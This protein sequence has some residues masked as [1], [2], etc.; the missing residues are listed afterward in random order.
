M[1]LRNACGRS[2]QQA[3]LTSTIA[4][5]GLTEQRLRD[6]GIDGYAAGEPGRVRCKAHPTSRATRS[7]A[8]TWGFHASHQSPRPQARVGMSPTLTGL[9]AD[10]HH[11][12]SRPQS[13]ISIGCRACC[14]DRM[15]RLQ[16]GEPDAHRC[17][18]ASSFSCWAQAWAGLQRIV[19]RRPPRCV[20]VGPS[21]VSS[22]PPDQKSARD[23]HQ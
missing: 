5:T 20:R 22:P 21:P 14:N 16:V 23:C 6:V 8:D 7:A 18:D 15:A 3:I 9:Y 4:E 19:R 1:S 13:E 17:A 12:A 11:A 10:V 2:G